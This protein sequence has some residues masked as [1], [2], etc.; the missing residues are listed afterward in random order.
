MWEQVAELLR[1]VAEWKHQVTDLWVGECGKKLPFRFEV[2]KYKFF[3]RVYTCFSPFLVFTLSPNDC[4][5]LIMSGSKI[6]KIKPEDVDCKTDSDFK[7]L[8]CQLFTLADDND[9]TLKS[10]RTQDINQQ[11]RDYIQKMEDEK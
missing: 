6:T 3:E 5:L 1:P 2:D 9:I 10:I 8:F 4:F 7:T 11:L